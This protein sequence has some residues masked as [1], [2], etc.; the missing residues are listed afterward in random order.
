MM[1]K[2]YEPPALTALGTFHVST[3]S[4]GLPCITSKTLGSPDYMFQIPAPITNCS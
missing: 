4:S 2:P 3:Q 1:S